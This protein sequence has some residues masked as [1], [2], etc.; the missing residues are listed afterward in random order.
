MHTQALCSAPLPRLAFSI[1]ESQAMSGLSRRFL[2]QLI[3]S[4]E[5][6]T[7]KRGGR[8]LVPST[9]LKRL[10]GVDDTT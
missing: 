9:E 3:A 1:A 8:R 4:G 10:C 6:R 5:L 2:Y 7:V